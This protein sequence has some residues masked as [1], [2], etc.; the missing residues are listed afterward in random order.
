MGPM[1][2]RPML[3]TGSSDAM[4]LHV[5]A[6]SDPGILAGAIRRELQIFDRNVPAYAIS[7]LEDRL[8]ASFAQ[9]RQAAMLTGVFGLLAL[10]LS[11]I[12]VYG[13]TAL[14]VT[15]R[16]RDIGIRIAL[17]AG[18]GDIIRAI[19]QRGF[20][21][22]MAGIGLGLLGSY[23]FTR[24]AASL[25]YGV[26]ARDSASFA[27]MSALLIVVAVIAFC[28]PARRATRLDAVAAIRYD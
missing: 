5:R 6:A 10:V 11:G 9:T 1:I 28:I 2:Y 15:R 24:F 27:G 21:L 19:G 18:R 8:N 14:V 3:Q 12:G 16:T 7:T 20:R 25:L 22:V 13:V 4:T 26:T 17:G 23:G